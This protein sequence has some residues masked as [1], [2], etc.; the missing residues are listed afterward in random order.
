MAAAELTPRTDPVPPDGRDR[1][2]RADDHAPRRERRRTGRTDFT[3]RIARGVAD[4]FTEASQAF[5]DELDET[6]GCADLV[7]RSITGLIRANARFLDELA[8]VLGRV[9]DDLIDG[10]RDAEARMDI[11]YD[12]LAELVA[13]KLRRTGVQ[14]PTAQTGVKPPPP[15]GGDAT[16]ELP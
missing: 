4:G 16:A 11:D 5:S 3:T 8:S 14:L 6:S 2:H 7:E 10:D 15:P 1:P 9:G 13:E 12:R